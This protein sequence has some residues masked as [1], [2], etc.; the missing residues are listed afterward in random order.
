MTLFMK[1]ILLILSLIFVAQPALAA[2]ISFGTNPRYLNVECNAEKYPTFIRYYLKGIFA[3]ETDANSISYRFFTIQLQP[4][5]P[6]GDIFDEK[7]TTDERKTLGLSAVSGFDIFTVKLTFTLNES[8]TSL[9][10][11]SMAGS[12]KLDP[13][14]SAI[15]CESN[16]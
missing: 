14:S 13:Q 9:L 4:G 3:Y 7:P 15:S 10:A 6:I 11:E 5:R 1:K 12:K 16:N 8:A 2:K